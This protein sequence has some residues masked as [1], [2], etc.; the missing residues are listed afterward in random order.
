MFAEISVQI[1]LVENKIKQNS[2][3]LV[4]PIAPHFIILTPDHSFEVT[5]LLVK[6]ASPRRL[7][8]LQPFN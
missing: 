2:F 5:L 3:D 8:F 1:G 6:E 4:K 7:D